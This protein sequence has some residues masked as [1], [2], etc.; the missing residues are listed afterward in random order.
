MATATLAAADTAKLPSTH[1]ASAVTRAANCAASTVSRA[2][3]WVRTVLTVPQPYSLP[4]MSAPSTS[5]SAPANTGN[6]PIALPTIP[7][8]SM[9]ASTCSRGTPAVCTLSSPLT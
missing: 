7:P 3:P 5:A 9:S 2:G 4:I 8:G 6:P 1:T